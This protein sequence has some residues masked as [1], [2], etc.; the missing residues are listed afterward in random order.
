MK[1]DFD[2]KSTL[3][4]FPIATEHKLKLFLSQANKF[5]DTITKEDSNETALENEGFNIVDYLY[6]NNINPTLS[7]KKEEK[8]EDKFLYHYADSIKDNVSSTLSNQQKRKIF[9]TI[10][11]IRLDEFNLISN[12]SVSEKTFLKNKVVP[13][14]KRRRENLDNIRKK[15]KTG[16]FNNF[17]Y[18]KINDA[19]ISKKSKLYFFKFPISF[20]NDIKKD[21]NKD[22]INISLL[23]IMLKKELYN[24]KDLINYN[25]NLK[26]IESKEIQKNEELNEILVKKYSELFKEYINSKEFNVNE[27]NRLKNN[28]MGNAYIEKYIYQSKNFIEYFSE[29][30]D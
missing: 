1:E 25:H 9:K 10:Y 23:E 6:L 17:I 12:S 26:V 21:T 11:R 4:I 29:I 13:T 14:K 7:L 27:I 20:V 19:L 15:I 30:N 16:F 22:I 3:L 8:A 28:N 18:K 2:K 24:E 5:S